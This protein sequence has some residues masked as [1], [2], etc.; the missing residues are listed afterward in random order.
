M[1]QLIEF[2]Q[3]GYTI[4]KNTI[5]PGAIQSCLE[6]VATNKEAATYLDDQNRPRRIERILNSGKAT[7]TIDSTAREI[8]KDIF[9]EEFTVFKDK[10]NFKPPLGE[11]FRCHYDGI[12][13]WRD[14]DGKERNGWHE[15]ADDFVNVLIALED[16]N[17]ENGGLEISSRV[18]LEFDKL[19]SH[20]N[21]DG[22]PF[23]RSEIEATLDFSLPRLSKGDCIIFSHKCPHRSARNISDLGR[24][25]LYFT[26]NRRSHGDFYNQYFLDKQ[27][28]TSR[29][30]KSLSSR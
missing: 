3:T 11:G 15:Y 28:S 1:R 5:G 8:L 7:K 6:E 17:A 24:A 14:S 2:S 22:T 20:T 4:V 10:L 30:D 19:L 29:T 16:S 9:G 13:I 26:Y 25:I 12:F 23:L 21:N 27:S 18:N